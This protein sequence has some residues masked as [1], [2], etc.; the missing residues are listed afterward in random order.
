MQRFPRRAWFAHGDVP[1]GNTDHGSSAGGCDYLDILF[2]V[3][4]SGSMFEE[5][6]NLRDNFPNFVQVL[7]DYVADPSKGALGY[8]LGVTNSSFQSDGSTTGLDGSLYGDP[9]CG[10]TT[11]AAWLDGPAPNIADNFGCLADLPRACGN[12]CSDNGRE[13]PLDT[14]AWFADKN[15][16]GQPNEGFYRGA[17][18]LFAIVTLTDE[19]DHS[20]PTVPAQTKTRLDSFAGGEDRYVIVT[21]AGQQNSGCV[22][23]LGEANAAPRLHEFTNMV[24]H[25]MVGDI[26]QGDL[27]T[28]LADAL[29]LLKF[30]CDTLPPPE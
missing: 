17:G 13:R 23:A 6:A 25:R 3:D 24:T 26:C 1:G 11:G 15:A 12:T 29:E 18:S 16:T 30:S 4:I 8:R 9:T 14:M 5:K 7:D 10:T 20:E 22:S 27:A 21:I 28:P 2:I 19:D